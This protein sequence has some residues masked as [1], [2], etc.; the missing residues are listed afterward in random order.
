MKRL[1][2]SP[3]TV[4]QERAHRCC[5]CREVPKI[6]HFE[7]T[8]LC[9]KY[10]LHKK[11]LQMKVVQNLISYKKVPERI[12]LSPSWN[13]ARGLKRL[14]W[15][16]YYYIVLKGQITFNL[17]LMLRIYFSILVWSIA[18]NQILEKSK[19]INFLTADLIDYRKID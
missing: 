2:T 1:P 13:G 12:C 19:K 5:N 18:R 3:Y 8:Q 11:K 14:I 17:G 10:G 7:L 4:W 15:L 6:C 9:Q 16:K